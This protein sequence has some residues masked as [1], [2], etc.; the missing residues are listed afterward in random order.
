VANVLVVGGAGYVGGWLTDRAREA[1]H[2][3]VV[4]DKL[5][6]E[7]TYMKEVNL[8]PGD[9]LDQDALRPWLRWADVVV[10]L[11][12]IVGDPACALDPELT[13][14]TNVDAVRR[15]VEDF[16]GRILF[17]ST[18]SV[19]GAQDGELT[20][21]S[22]LAPLSLYAQSKIDAEHILLDDAADAVIFRLGTLF[23]LGDA[24]SRLRA[25]LVLNVL[26]IRAVLTGRMSVFG[27]RQFRPLLHVRDVATAMV[28]NIEARSGG[29]YNLHTENVT[30]IGLADRIR[31]HVPGATIN[32]TE[33]TF[34][35][36][37]NYSVSSARAENDFGFAPR[38]S[39]DDGIAEVARVVR[40]GRIK[41][42]SVARFS[43]HDAL[44]PLLTSEVTPLGTVYGVRG[45]VGVI[46]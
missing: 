29:V 10:W 36:A 6:Y 34:Q 24:F 2:D 16:R 30:I 39:V 44:K 22:P 8:V 7:D 23:G 41:D 26:T 20:E 19:Y 4:Y 21:S 27:G 9:V 13:T 14:A 5:L 17:P 32:V 35:D 12:A 40:E 43:N 38:W 37:R 18:C 33:A 45:K 15:L 31:N 1:G 25:D 42:V 46:R 3:V 11:A 28:P